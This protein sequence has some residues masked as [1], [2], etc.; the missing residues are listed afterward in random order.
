[1]ALARRLDGTVRFDMEI[2]P[3]ACT[4]TRAELE[5][6][7]HCLIPGLLKRAPGLTPLADGVRLEFDAAPDVLHDVTAVIERER[8]CCRF[9]QFV[10]TVPPGGKPFQ[11]EITGPEGTRDFFAQISEVATP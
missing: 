8:Q 11:L 6:D 4:L 7:A 9:L 5:H 10:L 2:L 1:V 3:I